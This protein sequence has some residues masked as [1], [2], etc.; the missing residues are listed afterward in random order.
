[1]R[2]K[3]FAIA[4]FAVA[5]AGP[6]AGQAYDPNYPVC[7]HVYGG[8]VGGGNYIDCSFTSIPQ[9]QASASGR[10]AMCSVNPFFAP[11]PPPKRRTH[12]RHHAY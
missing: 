4:A 11:P 6:A 12:R 2:L 1:M 9:C 3:L 10:G 5:L 8:R 7:M